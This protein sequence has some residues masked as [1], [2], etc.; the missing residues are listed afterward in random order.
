MPNEISDEQLDQVLD[1]L[2][3]G[4]KLNAVKLYRKI[5][6]CTLAEAKNFVEKLTDEL[7][8]AVPD[9]VPG[10]GTGCSAALLFIVVTG[11]AG[12]AMLL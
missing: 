6:G 7:G 10:Q 8:D 11:S 2:K 9:A 5:S 12:V 4:R 3:A 1:E